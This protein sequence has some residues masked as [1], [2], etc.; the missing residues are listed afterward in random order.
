MATTTTTGS[1]SAAIPAELQPYFVGTPT[2]PGLLPTA[3]GVFGRSYS[4]VFGPIG[5]AGLL[6]AGRIA[7]LTKDQIDLGKTIRGMQRPDQFAT[8]SGFINT[9][10]DALT[11]LTNQQAA[12]VSAPSLNTFQLGN[13]QTFGFDQANQY[14]SP[15]VQAALNPQLDALRRQNAIDQ[16]AV[17]ARFAGS[18]AFGGGRQAIGM[19]QANA[20]TAR[21]MNQAIGT[22]YQNAFTQAQQQ[23]ERDRAAQAGVNTQNLNA[24]LNVQQLGATQNLTAQELNQK[25]G[26][27]AAAQRADAARN[28]GNLAAQAGQLGTA[29]QATDIDRIKMMGA[30]GDLERG[31]EQ[32]KLD[33]RYEGLL[34]QIRF[35]EEQLGGMSSILRGTPLNSNVYNSTQ[36]TSP[37]SLIGQLANAGVSGLSLYN[38]M[39][40]KN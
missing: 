40:P 29:Q 34:R 17:G 2:S 21:Q 3:Q 33:A 4:D 36:L 32:Q 11:D 24:A 26:L 31:V 9:G 37:P 25:A 39:Q 16:Q 30:Q 5:D 12:S 14:M 15:F 22:G 27:L 7:G 1:N 10:G 20:E 19:A 35:P 23:F 18:G 28:L 6:G 13:A 8:A 38:L